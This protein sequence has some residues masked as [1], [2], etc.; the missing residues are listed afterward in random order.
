[1]SSREQGGAPAQPRVAT[2]A[3]ESLVTRVLTDAFERDGVYGAWAFPDPGT[4][5]AN[6]HSLFRF[7]VRGALRHGWT[8]IA[9]AE[10]A[11]TVWI[12]PAAGDLSA[13]QE[14]ELDEW[15][16]GSDAAVERL[17]AG[18]V[19]LEAAR[20]DAPHFHLSLFGTDPAHARGGHGQ[21]LLAHDLALIDAEGAAAYLD[22]SDE[23]VPLYERF[24]FVRT[25]GF[26]LP[27]GPRTNTMWRD[28][29][30]AA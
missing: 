16:R 18:F 22:T 21:A 24:G 14:V 2:A 25:G 23:L 15:L 20:P 1:M 5:R 4:R 12:P 19:L 17:L 6:R 26:E 3:D 9:P 27:D 11:V 13:E 10:H 8:W 30:P 29:R 7:L 28:P